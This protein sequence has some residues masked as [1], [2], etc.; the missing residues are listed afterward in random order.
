[1]LEARGTTFQRYALQKLGSNTLSY[2]MADSLKRLEVLKATNSKQFSLRFYYST[3]FCDPKHI[4]TSSNHKTNKSRTQQ[5]KATCRKFILHR[6]FTKT[7]PFK[8]GVV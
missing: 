1:M 7:D 3:Q 4:E 5:P 6:S 2:H 8:V